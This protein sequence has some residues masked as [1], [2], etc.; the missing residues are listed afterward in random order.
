[1]EIEVPGTEEAE[2][3]ADMWVALAADQRRHGSHLRADDNRATIRESVVRHVVTGTLLVARGEDGLAGFVMF[4]VETGSLEQ[5]VRRGVVENLYVVADARGRGTGGRLLSA[6]EAVLSDRG[7][8]VV[9]LE[10]MAENESARE[11]YRHR[12]YE[13]HRL[14]LEK[15]LESDTDTRADE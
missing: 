3:I 7:A 4:S 12:G 13:P 15:P 5:D 2:S 1:M 10:A 9:A 14:E 11:F 6:A 8:D